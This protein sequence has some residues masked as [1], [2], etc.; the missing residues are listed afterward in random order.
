MCVRSPNFSTVAI[1][2]T[3]TAANSSQMMVRRVVDVAVDEAEVQRRGEQDEEAEDDL[4]EVHGGLALDRDARLTSLVAGPLPPGCEPTGPALAA[5]V[6][7]A[8]GLPTR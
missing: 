6:L 3:T 7:H 4:L 5:I 2:L 8:S 1:R